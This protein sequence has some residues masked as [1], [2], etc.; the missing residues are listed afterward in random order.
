MLRR[1][2]YVA[3][4]SEGFCRGQNAHGTSGLERGIFDILNFVLG[5]G[6]HDVPLPRD[7]RMRADMLFELRNGFMLAVEYDGAFWHRG[8]LRRDLRKSYLLRDLR[9]HEVVRIRETPLEP[10]SALDVAVPRN[11][12]AVLCARVTLAHV[13][14]MLSPCFGN[15][16]IQRIEHSLLASSDDL[17][18]DAVACTECRKLLK[19]VTAGRVPR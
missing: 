4:C 10:T 15:Q 14:H 12:T 8:Q 19:V 17:D 5:G 18:R 7:R 3:S 9:V 16:T 1:G 11:P 6:A 2:R 13:L